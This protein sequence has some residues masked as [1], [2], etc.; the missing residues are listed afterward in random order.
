MKPIKLVGIALMVLALASCVQKSS[1]KTVVLKLH[2]EGLKNIQT[3][4]VRGNDKPLSWDYDT[5]L[6]P[7]KKDSLYTTTFSLV[8]GY[9][10]TEIKF[11]V[12][13]QFE[14]NDK[15]NRKIRFTDKDTT[16]YEARYDVL[17]P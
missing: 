1:K 5:E 13:G 17:N 12:N 3:V 2:V 15:G 8:T 16:V 4:G 14:L 11:T 7:L 10:F 6:K 9:T